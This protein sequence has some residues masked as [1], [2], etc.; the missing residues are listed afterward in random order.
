MED[1][2]TSNG[3]QVGLEPTSKPTADAASFSPK[4]RRL[5]YHIVRAHDSRARL[6][7]G[8]PRIEASYA[9]VD[10]A[11]ESAGDPVPLREIRARCGVSL[12]TLARLSGV[13]VSTIHRVEHGET[14]PRPRVVRAVSAA[15]GVAPWQVVEFQL[16]LATV[17]L[18][19]P[20][21]LAS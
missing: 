10:R 7:Y 2:A 17:G 6:A 14:V 15:L 11:A 4:T 3:L 9:A 13:S 12:P 19:R 18:P 1:T 8:R 5:A 16:V 20:T 21:V